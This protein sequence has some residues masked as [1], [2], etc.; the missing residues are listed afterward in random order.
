[1]V[2]RV[3]K[4]TMLIPV[5]ALTVFVL[6]ERLTDTFGYT[7]LTVLNGSKLVGLLALLLLG[8]IICVACVVICARYLEGFFANFFLNAFAF[9][10]VGAIHLFTFGFI[11]ITASVTDEISAWGNFDRSAEQIL[12]QSAY[13]YFPRE[14][15]YAKE[16]HYHYGRS[17]ALYDELCITATQSLPRGDYLSYKREVMNAADYVLENEYGKT[18]CK[19]FYMDERGMIIT[20]DDGLREINYQINY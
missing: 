11:G 20:F 18:V 17:L 10:L 19:F 6:I 4:L 15:T 12:N 14:A 8:V 9:I 5:V 1:M 16:Y 2:R 13:A 7:H 3:L